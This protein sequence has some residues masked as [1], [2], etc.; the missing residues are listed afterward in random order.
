[1]IS[2][3]PPHDLAAERAVI[4]AAIISK[5]AIADISPEAFYHTGHQNIWREILRLDDAGIPIDVVSLIPALTG[6]KALETLG[7]AAAYIPGL[8]GEVPTLAHAEH[9]A[10]RVK[11]LARRRCL[12]NA[13]MVAE[14]QAYE[15]DA[16]ADTIE[17]GLLESFGS[18]ESAQA[19]K[20]GREVMKKVFATLERRSQGEKPD[21]LRTGFYDLDKICPLRPGSLTV[22]AAR[23]AMGKTSLGACLL[24][25]VMADGGNVAFFSLEMID[26]EIGELMLAQVSG[27]SRLEMGEAKF[28]PEQF[29]AMSKGMS[30][31]LQ[32]GRLFLCDNT[33]ITPSYIRRHTLR[34]HKKHP[35]S[36]LVVDY[37][38]LM[39]DDKKTQSRELEIS[40]ISR[41]LKRLAKELK[42]AVVELSQ[43]N[44]MVEGRPDRE[45][46]LSDLRES[47]SLE[48]DANNVWMVFRPEV[49][50]PMPESEAERAALPAEDYKKRESFQ[51]KAI[52][53]VR[54]ARGG[55]IGKVGLRWNG[56]AQKFESLS[57]Y[58]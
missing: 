39:E 55:R 1:M 17:A 7:G 46:Q 30:R 48:Q 13:C 5:D 53:F 54:K 34:L 9:Y 14:S 52:I 56:T 42:I 57:F 4:G 23:P 6:D 32:A 22:L 58:D 43:L 25:N 24:R 47:G 35:L 18:D 40:A 21:I 27:V 2:R 51:D 26:E 33:N 41:S 31:M 20:D 36:M 15:R 28:T 11:D 10:K 19:F 8:T 44:R 29:A 45:P 16:D 38:Q 37:T 12:I 49:Y 50:W 3:V